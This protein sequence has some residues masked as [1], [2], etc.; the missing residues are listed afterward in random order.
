VPLCVG[1]PRRCCPI[2]LELGLVKCEQ[3][4]RGP[5]GPGGAGNPAR[6]P[7][8]GGR[9]RSHGL[10]GPLAD[11][12]FAPAM[13]RGPAVGVDVGVKS[14]VVL[15]TGEVLPNSKYLSRH[16]RRMARLQC[17]CSRRAGQAPGAPAK[18]RAPSKCRQRS[19]V[20]L[21][22]AHA[23]V[24]RTRTDGSHKLT[25][26]LAT[27]HA[28]MVIED[29]GVSGMTAGGRGSGGG[30][31]RLGSTVQSSMPLPASYNASSPSR[32]PRTARLSSRPT[33]GTHPPRSARGARQ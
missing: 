19:K 23:K 5:P 2:R 21:D 3:P 9:A 1:R 8:G 30:E 7:P 15:S 18:G 28:T 25:A 17:Q 27:N 24:A 20:R 29:L 12:V 11:D 16:A 31:A 32:T 14:L 13:R 33:V 6:L 22:R 26:C 10:S 4:F